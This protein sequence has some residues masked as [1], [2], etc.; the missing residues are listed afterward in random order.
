MHR[1]IRVIAFAV[2]LLVVSTVQAERIDLTRAVVVIR[3]GDLPAAEKVAS[4]ILTEEIA[5]RTGLSW[6]V[7]SEWPAKA[8]VVIAISTIANSP[9]WVGH[10][11][12]ASST[13]SSKAE[14]F[15]ITVAAAAGGKPATIA[16]TG[17]DA[18]GVMFGVGKL[19]RSVDWKSGAASIG[20]DFQAAETPDRPL[21]GHQVGYRD[22]ANSWDA[23]TYDQYEQYFREMAIFGANAVENIPF[24]EDKPSPLFK[25]TRDKMNIKF[26]ELCDKYDLQHWIWLPVLI[27]LPDEDKEVEFLKQQA[28]FYT[29]IKRLDA[30]FV[31]GGDPGNN[32][33]NVLLPHL[34][35]TAALVRKSHP[36][37]KIWLSLQ[38]FKP[39]D[40]EFLYNYLEQQ[41]PI[42]FGGLVM[43]PSSP[44]MEPTR[45]RLPK[46]YQLRWYPDITHSVRCQY[47]IPWLDP[48]LGMTLGREPVNPRPVDY[49]D[50][51]QMD[52]RF[53][54]GFLS[55]SD[56]VHDD[57]NKSL[58][59]QLGWNPLVNPRDVAREY[60][61]FFFG[62][63][64]AEIG[65]DGL[66][67]LES[68]TRGALADRGSVTATYLLWKEMEQ[69][70]PAPGSK[71]RFGM[72]L[73]RAYYM[74]FT[75]NRLI[76]ET[77]LERQALA[78]LDEADKIG[79]TPAMT[80]ARAVLE[81]AKSQPAEPELIKRLNQF[82]E[83]LFREIGLQTSV[84]K[85]KANNSQ[86]GAVLDFLDYP[87]NNR[88]WLEDQFDKIE[89]MSDPKA[90]LRRLSIVRNW[91]N[92]GK[93]GYY[94]VLGHVGKSPRVMK[95]LTAGDIMRHEDEVPA[96]NQRWMREVKTPLR[97]AWH[98]YLY[99]LTQPMT[100]NDLDPNS[101]YVV[102]LFSQRSSPLV[103]DGVKA[104]LLSTG[105]TFDKVTE[106]IFEVPLEATQDGRIILTWEKLDES[107]L[108][109]RDRHYVTELWVMKRPTN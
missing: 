55:Y 41:K 75:R 61:R 56:G 107:D 93:Q 16:I 12:T 69:R 40:V 96:P 10:V 24:Q 28:E 57:F 64:L 38:Y 52:Y 66:F 30:I 81:L 87:L 43:G 50:I 36:T 90:Q 53:T 82:G 47:P 34:E 105:E 102:K 46:S 22:T 9:T 72:H 23:W 20:A 27:N 70:L 51:Y 108:N 89:T 73:F 31:P 104:K 39:D 44:P 95:L 32:K 45:I 42:W 62:A 54:D 21:R 4:T 8:D 77:D 68:D 99:R 92:P 37:V 80:K 11:S 6:K 14:S 26:A 2:G 71:W 94:D 83:E 58:W 74:Y 5:R 3:S 13:V 86:R 106:Q 63:E 48:A 33:A 101:P 88:W 67:S 79:A 103:I 60:S 65:A 85:Y 25:Y 35:R 29:K 18:R 76:Y 97:Q 15:A 100:Y 19:L 98:A 17:Y 59:T 7:V 49:T 84:P 109:W 91:E 1:L 78:K